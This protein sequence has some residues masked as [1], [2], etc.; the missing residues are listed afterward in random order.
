MGIAVFSSFS[1]FPTAFLAFSF[2]FGI[3]DL[4]ADSFEDALEDIGE[5]EP[6]LVEGFLALDEDFLDVPAVVADMSE[7]VKSCL[8]LSELVKSCLDIGEGEP[9]LVEGFF[10]LDDL[11]C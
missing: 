2:L 11:L 6:S 9:S 8:D 3:S 4:P 1:F 7:R 5:G 10:A